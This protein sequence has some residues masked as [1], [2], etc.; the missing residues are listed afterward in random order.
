MLI[1]KSHNWDFSSHHPKSNPQKNNNSGAT[2]KSGRTNYFYQK[3]EASDPRDE[4]LGTFLMWAA[5][6]LQSNTSNRSRA[7]EA[8]DIASI[9]IFR[10]MS[11]SSIKA[12]PSSIFLYFPF[13][14][15]KDEDEMVRVEVSGRRLSLLFCGGLIFL[16][17][18]FFQVR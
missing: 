14:E 18:V 1:N 5:I 17:A 10:G 15:T 6:D 4:K 12:F 11:V 16:G 7:R 13:T 8:E 3:E 2:A 9:C